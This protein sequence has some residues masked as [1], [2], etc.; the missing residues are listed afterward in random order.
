MSITNPALAVASTNPSNIVNKGYTP[1]RKIPL[2]SQLNTSHELN[3]LSKNIIMKS[4]QIEIMTEE[5]HE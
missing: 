3:N 1:V 4:Q 5:I 2:Y